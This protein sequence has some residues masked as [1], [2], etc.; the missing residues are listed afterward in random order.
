LG[1]IA[2]NV[3]FRSAT[4]LC[5]LVTLGCSPR[6]IEGTYVFRSSEVDETLELRR[7]GEFRQ[8]VKMGQDLYS[9]TGRWS[10][11]SRDL[12]LR[13]EFFVRFDI[14]KG[15]T[16]KPPLEVSLCSAYW[17]ARKS[18]ISFNEDYDAQYFVKRAR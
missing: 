17:D 4:L 18:R 15:K 2:M 14:F 13:G 11:A 8:Q 6:S 12:K 1:Q 10:L 3:L 9:A 7:G 16:L 5:L